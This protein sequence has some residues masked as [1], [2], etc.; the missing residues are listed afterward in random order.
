VYAVESHYYPQLRIRWSLCLLGSVVVMLAQLFPGAALPPRTSVWLPLHWALGI[1]SYG[2]FG[3][4]VAHAWYMG[5]AEERMRKAADLGR[6]MPLLTIERLTF[7]FV[8]AGFVLLTATLL[9]AFVFSESLYG[10]GVGCAGTTRPSSRCCRGSPLPRCCWGVP[11]SA[12]A[13]GARHGCCMSVPA[14]CSWPTWVAF[15]AGSVLGASHEVPAGS[16]RRADRFLCLALQP[17]GA[18]PASGTAAPRETRPAP[19]PPSRW[20]SAH[21]AGIHCPST[22][23]IAGKQPACTARPSTGAKPSPD[24]L[25]PDATPDAPS[26]LD[27]RQPAGAPLADDD[28][29]GEFVRL[30]RGFMTAR[31]TLGL[32]LLLLQAT[33]HALGQAPDR[34]LIFVC[35]I[36]LLATLGTRLLGRPRRLGPTFDP[37]WVWIIGADVAAFAVLQFVQ[38]QSGINYTPL[39]ALPVLLASVLGGLALAMGTAASVTLLLLAQAGLLSLR[40]APDAA[41]LL[42]QTALTGAGYFVIAFLSTQVAARLASEEQ[43]SQR[44]R[45]AVRVQRQVNELVIETLSDGIMVVDANGLVWAANPAAGRLWGAIR[46]PWERS[47]WDRIRGGANWR[48]GCRHVSR[49]TMGSVAV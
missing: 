39:L 10:Q 11:G 5:R 33:L 49:P 27:V 48:G 38:G 21:A 43:R 19:R 26:W 42:A 7:R 8:T 14:C 31:V 32:V 35:G 15:R 30:W 24:R 18:R 3:V 17:R 28:E 45:L 29:P 20:S 22:D 16:G 13:G 36:Y 2:L 25:H 44:N 4:A 1:A 9:V 34:L 12:G 37:Q 23:A 46:L 6:G 40:Q 47:A 41:P